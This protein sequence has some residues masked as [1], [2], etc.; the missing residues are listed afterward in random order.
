M[1]HVFFTIFTM[2]FTQFIFAQSVDLDKE[3]IKVSYV[4]LPEKPVLDPALRTYY[5]KASGSSLDINQL[6]KGVSIM[7]WTKN[8]SNGFYIVDLGEPKVRLFTANTIEE[9]DLKDGKK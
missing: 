7:G 8:T 4:K 6:K 1:R 9:T 5:I 2:L 3:Q